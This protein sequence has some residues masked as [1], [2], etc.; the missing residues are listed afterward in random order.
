MSFFV[1]NVE[2]KEATFNQQEVKSIYFNTHLIWETNSWPAAGTPLRDWTWK[3]IINLCNS[4]EDVRQY[5]S[6]GDTRSLV[7]TTG[8]V[9]PVAIGDFYHNTITGTTNTAAIAFTFVNC[10]N[11]KYAMNTSATN[12]GGWDSSNM[13]KTHMPNILATFPTELTANNAIKYVDVV[14]SAGLMSTR[15]ITS[16]DR[17]RLH[18]VTELVGSL[19]DVITTAI[20]GTVYPYYNSLSDIRKSANG[21]SVDYWTRSPMIP[22]YPEFAEPH[23][24]TNFCFFYDVHNMFAAT[25]ATVEYGVACAFDI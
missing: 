1:N 25:D 10:L 22:Q 17:L 14:A 12:Q 4:G 6:I 8:E 18:S 3:E 23:Q 15:L 11:T 20:E 21:N 7:L 5:F 24:K 13:R 19:S 9:V 16:S 2:L